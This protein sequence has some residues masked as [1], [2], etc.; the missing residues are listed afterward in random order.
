MRARLIRTVLVTS[1]LAGTLG[2]T[3]CTTGAAPDAQEQRNDAAQDLGAARQAALLPLGTRIELLDRAQLRARLSG[4]GAQAGDT[5][6]TIAG[7]RDLAAAISAAPTADEVRA[8]VT[9][10]G[11][12]LDPGEAPVP[13]G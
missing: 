9:R 5:A 10:A 7:Y 12:D 1:A 4:D 8:L 13:Q 6:A 2:L 11:V 3:A